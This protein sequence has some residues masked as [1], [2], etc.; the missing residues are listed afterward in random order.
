MTET[1]NPKLVI[2][3]LVYSKDYNKKAKRADFAIVAEGYD[4]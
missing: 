3:D 2:F 1:Q 4:G